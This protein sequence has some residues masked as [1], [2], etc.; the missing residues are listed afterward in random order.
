[1][2]AM[3]SLADCGSTQGAKI[4]L[5]NSTPSAAMV[6][7]LMS[8]F[9]TSVSTSPRGFLPTSLMDDQSIWIIIG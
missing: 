2:P 6:K 3:Y 9:T 7:G 5:K 4:T 1:M 8:Q